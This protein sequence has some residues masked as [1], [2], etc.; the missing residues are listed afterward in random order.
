MF[1]F[2]RFVPASLA[3]VVMAAQPFAALAQT[4]GVKILYGFVPG[5]AGDLL[6]RIVAERLQPAIG[7]SVVVENRAGASGKIALKALKGAAPDG[8]TLYIGPSGP[9]TIIPLHDANAGYDPEI[10]FAA[11]SQLVTFE[12]GLAVG[13]DVPAK[14]LTELVAWLKANPGKGNYGT[15]GAGTSMH[16][17][18]L[19][20]AT[21]TGLDLR[22]VHYRGSALAISDVVSGQLPL[23]M[24]PVADLLEQHRAGAVRIVAT[25]DN[26]RSI[27]VPDV[28]TFIEQGLD[29]RAGAWYAAYAPAKTPVDIVA[30]LSRIMSETVQAAQ[31]KERLY[32]MGFKA[33]GS[34]PEF[35]AQT[36]KRELEFWRPI[37]KASG[38]K[39]ED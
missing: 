1:V 19:K 38:F 7:Q 24:L 29:V 4:Q 2:R 17:L 25:S 11:V 8:S 22:P 36:Q 20:L 14:S 35:L 34:S 9:M 3:C 23:A 27:F 30:R 6:S 12:F 31:T 16:F 28:P 26:E 13:K 15:S 18:G 39:S 33:T 10:D 5:S 37:V 21:A 32:T